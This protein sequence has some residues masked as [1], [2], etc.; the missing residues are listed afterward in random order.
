MSKVYKPFKATVKITHLVT[1]SC[2]TCDSELKAAGIEN[3]CH[4]YRCISCGKRI[5]VDQ[6]YPAKI[7]ETVD[8][9]VSQY[10]NVLAAISNKM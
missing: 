5:G 3:N 7:V 2:D 8:L 6:P 4:Y 1:I 10:G 9:P